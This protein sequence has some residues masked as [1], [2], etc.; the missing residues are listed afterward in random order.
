MLR[1]HEVAMSAGQAP[2]VQLALFL[3]H[4]EANNDSVWASY[5][6]DFAGSQAKPVLLWSDEGLQELQGTQVLETALQYRCDALCSTH[7]ERNAPGRLRVRTALASAWLAHKFVYARRDFFKAKHEQ[8]V[9]S[10][11]PE[12]DDASRE[13]CTLQRFTLAAAAVRARLFPPFSNQEPCVAAGLEVV[14]RR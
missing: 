9:T 4:A 1:P 3:I 10:L 8:L 13:A 6:A 7:S 12:L 14:R 2:W 11:L 5:L